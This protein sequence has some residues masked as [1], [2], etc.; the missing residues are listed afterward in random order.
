LESGKDTFHWDYV[1]KAFI[2]MVGYA[3]AAL[4]AGT[5]LFEERELS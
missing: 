4:A 5:A 1:G 2:Y 3:G